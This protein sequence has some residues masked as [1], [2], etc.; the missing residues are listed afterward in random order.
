MVDLSR[1]T[2]SEYPYDDQAVPLLCEEL[3]ITR[4]CAGARARFTV[5]AKSFG[6]EWRV[7]S[8]LALKFVL[9][10]TVLASSTK[11]AE[12]ENLRVTLPYLNYYTLLNCSREFVLILPD[13]PWKG[14]AS[15][16]PTHK[17]VIN[18]TANALR[19]IDRDAERR[20]GDVLRAA[21]SHRELFS[22]RF[23]GSG[24]WLVDKG[25]IQSRMRRISPGS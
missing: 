10:A 2:G 25:R 1:L 24:P 17:N 11:H 19:R 7:R 15:M 4:Y 8:Y 9:G 12:A 21:R 3:D 23:P 22:Y 14:Q 13:Q 18:I 5:I 16:E 20:W 6:V